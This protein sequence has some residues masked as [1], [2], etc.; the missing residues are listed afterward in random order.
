MGDS[1]TAQQL[2]AKLDRYNQY[3]KQGSGETGGDGPRV[4]VVSD[5]GALKWTNLLAGT[6]RI[7]PS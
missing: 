4:V 5:I 3:L 6:H 7:W 2:K 1:D